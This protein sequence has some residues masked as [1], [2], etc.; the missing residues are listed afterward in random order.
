M[1]G[2]L[3]AE[4]PVVWS[5]Y[6]ADAPWVDWLSREDGCRQI[7]SGL[8]ADPEALLALLGIGDSVGDWLTVDASWHSNENI[9]IRMISALAPP[10]GTV[11]LVRWLPH[12]G[13]TREHQQGHQRTVL[14]RHD[15][16]FAQRQI[17]GK[18]EPRS[19]RAFHVH[20]ACI[21]SRLGRQCCAYPEA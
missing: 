1:A 5:G 20:S 12:A 3:L 8:T 13:V 7:V 16:Q 17:C 14:V 21:A 9:E 19:R 18:H 10:G 15:I 4:Y 11:A 6:E 2:D